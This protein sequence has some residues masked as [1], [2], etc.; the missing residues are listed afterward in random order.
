LDLFV[1]LE[2]AGSKKEARRLIQ[3][4][5]AR[6]GDDKISDENSKLTVESFG[7]AKEVTL[8]AGKKRAGVVELQD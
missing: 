7:S 6:L 2:L 8:K 5:G 3:G 4:G 1:K